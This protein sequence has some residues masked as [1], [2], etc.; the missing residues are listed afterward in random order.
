MVHFGFWKP[1]S[2]AHKEILEKLSIQIVKDIPQ[3]ENGHQI[4]NM[5][6][7]SQPQEMGHTINHQILKHNNRRR[8]NHRDPMEK[9]TTIS[10]R[11]RGGHYSLRERLQTMPT[12]ENLT[13]R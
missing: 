10:L 13:D 1:K 5:K 8:R 11:K 6:A 9:Q 2:I 4:L 7:K 12:K 3:R